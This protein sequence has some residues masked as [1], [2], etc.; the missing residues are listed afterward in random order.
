MES[1]KLQFEVQQPKREYKEVGGALYDVS[2]VAPKI[3]VGS[4]ARPAGEVLEAMQVL[5]IQTPVNQL[6]DTERSR[7]QSYIDRKEERKAPKVSVDLTD[8]TAVARAQSTIVGDWRNV[9]KD[10]GAQEVADRYLS[11]Y[12]AVEQGNAGNKAADGALIYSVGKIYDPSGAVQE[13]DKATILGNRNIPDRI[14]AFAQNVF[15]G[16]SLLPSE[17]NQLLQVVTEQVKSRAQSI[18]QQV[19]PYVQIS[20][21]LGGDGSLLRN[22]LSDALTRAQASSSVEAPSSLQEQAQRE[23]ERRRRRQ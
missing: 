7:I 5:G 19:M 22:P 8:P 20:K 2:G 9:I 13:G 11:A 12:K 14:K 3:V 18:D 23:L 4:Q 21:S 17:R 16:A 1:I 15:S 10:S 6:N